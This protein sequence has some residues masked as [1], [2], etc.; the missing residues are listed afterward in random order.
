MAN[1]KYIIKKGSSIDTKVIA[2]VLHSEPYED[3]IYKSIGRRFQS[4]YNSEENKG[5]VLGSHPELEE[6]RKYTIENNTEN[7]FSNDIENYIENHLP[8]RESKISVI[9]EFLNFIEY[10]HN[11]DKFDLKYYIHLQQYIKHL[12]SMN[13]LHKDNAEEYSDFL[14][15][16]DLKVKQ[17]SISISES[18]SKAI[19]YA[20]YEHQNWR[21]STNNLA[22]NAIHEMDGYIGFSSKSKIVLRFSKNGK[23]KELNY[24]QAAKLISIKV[25]F[26]VK[27]IENRRDKI[28]DFILNEDGTMEPLINAS[29]VEISIYDLII[30][31]G[32]K[33]RPFII[34]EFYEDE[35][36]WFRNIFVPTK[37]MKLGA[38]VYKEPTAIFS[39]IYNLVNYDEYRF[40]YV[41]NWLANFF[42]TLKKSQVALVLLGKQGAGKG[43]FFNHI[44][45]ALFDS[46]YCTEINDSTLGSRYRAE[47]IANR[48]FYN[49]DESINTRSSVIKNFIKALITNDTIIQETKGDNIKDGIEISGQLLITSNHPNPV[50]IEQND[51]RFSVFTTGGNIARK[52]FLGYGDHDTL[53]DNIKDELEDFAI[54]LK[55]YSVDKELADR[56]LNTPEK[57]SI[58]NACSDNFQIFT[59]AIE[60]MNIKAFQDLEEIDAVLYYTLMIDF[61]HNRV[62]RASLPKIFKALYSGQKNN[63]SRNELHAKLRLAK[64]HIFSDDNIFPSSGK[65][66]FRL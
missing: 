32:E 53:I 38:G 40:R 24:K 58:I 16:F 62:D 42:Q 4:D 64:P 37:Y 19:I 43:I 23:F 46:R 2:N 65:K 10:V 63:L 48:L 5:A 39:L 44:I 11:M 6:Y 9:S 45:A 50:E 30:L 60:N 35:G 34:K 55:S 59:D 18:A 21:L 27:I 56:A 12:L 25:G 49:I 28:I 52:N 61:T 31:E 29:P 41:M 8:N 3:P 17:K 33:F 13:L 26:D 14:K 7:D 15:S 54:Y 20:N 66:Y 1:R 47:T 51:R 22:I 57:S 36:E